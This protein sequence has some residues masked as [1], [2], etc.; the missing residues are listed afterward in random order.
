MT[1]Y[2]N[3]PD[4]HIAEADLPRLQRLAES[5]MH[6]A[7][8][9][10]DYLQRELS[11]A[12]LCRGGADEPRR[13]QMGSQV[14]FSDNGTERV[15]SVRLVYPGEEDVVQGKISV[16]TPIGAALLGLGEGQSIDWQTRDGAWRKLTVV[17]IGA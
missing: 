11:R 13:V 7:P 17:R 15:R 4:I 6:S 2:E 5:G 1:M 10:A 3:L 12:V 9:V 8:D 14:E 16:L